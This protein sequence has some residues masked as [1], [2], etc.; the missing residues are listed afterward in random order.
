MN[1]M[2][3]IAL[4]LLTLMIGWVLFHS[5][6]MFSLWNHKNWIFFI[7]I[8]LI[9]LSSHFFR[10]L[11]LVLL[12]LEER[13]KVFPLASAHVLTAFPAS[14]LPFKLGEI[15]RLAYFMKIYNWRQKALVVWLVERFGDMVVLSIFIIILYVLNIDI[16]PAMRVFFV[17]FVV[18]TIAG[19]LCLIALTSIFLHLNR[20]L[21]QKSISSRGLYILRVSHIFRVLKFSINKTIE[22]RLVG[23]L[24]LSILIWLLEILA[25][26]LFSENFSAVTSDF[27]S[28]FISSLFSS[29]SDI[30]GGASSIAY[31]RS[32]LLLIF[33]LLFLAAICLLLR[34]KPIRR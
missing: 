23:F 8:G 14:L 27:A 12:T 16:P 3:R 26:A 19:F 17:I 1:S 5:D 11:R 13:D 4:I 10:I 7:G 34:S 33:T 30:E 24:I 31:Y 32:A 2:S 18:V 9:Y 21:V 22:G 28:H 6:F 20:H 15:F 29:L 25:L